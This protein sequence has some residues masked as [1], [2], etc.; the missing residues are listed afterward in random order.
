MF[1]WLTSWVRSAFLA[2][3]QQGIDALADGTHGLRLP[4]REEAPALPAPAAEVEA[5]SPRRNG[6]R[7][8]VQS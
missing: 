4:G 6:A 1:A 5:E 2:G 8:A 3:V 7:K